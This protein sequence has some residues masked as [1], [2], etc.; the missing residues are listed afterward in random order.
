MKNATKWLALSLLVTLISCSTN[1]PLDTPAKGT[2]S[3]V[4]DESL[5]PLVNELTGTYSGIYPDAHFKVSY[6]P[7][8]EA[9][10]ALLRDEARIAFTTRAL[11]PDEQA[12][13]NQRKIPGKAERIATDGVALIINKANTDSL[14][15]MSELEWV[16]Q[17]KISTWAQL[18]GGNQSGPITLVF[19]NDNSSNLNFVLKTFKITDVKSLRIFTVKSNAEVIAFVRQNPSALGFIGVNWISDGDA[20]LSAR[21]SA[22]LR[23]V[24][25][26]PKPNPVG[27]ADYY[28]P[29][30]RSLGLQ[31]YPL[32]RPVYVLSREAHAG[33]GG[34]LL[35]YIV[36]DAGGLIIEKLGLWPTKPYNREVYLKP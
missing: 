25:L 36:R 11:T 26:S 29:F 34:G 4:A 30:Q 24:G 31:E 35:N 5:Q 32:R 17:A 9:I 23:V 33:L 19:D 8:Q 13:L 22:N 27:L 3:V 20:P 18:K 2:I 14:L 16:F 21:L 10:N 28:Q 1:P 7:E 15:T 6:K 12:V